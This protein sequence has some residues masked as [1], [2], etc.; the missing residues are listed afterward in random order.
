[1]SSLICLGYY[2]PNTMVDHCNTEINNTD[3]GLAHETYGMIDEKRK[4]S[5]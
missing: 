4:Q 5:L 2:A 3:N 1:M